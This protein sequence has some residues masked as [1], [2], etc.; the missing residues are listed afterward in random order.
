M[1]LRP[2]Q[3][4]AYIFKPRVCAEGGGRGTVLPRSMDMTERLRLGESAFKERLGGAGPSAEGIE[5]NPKCPLGRVEALASLSPSF[6]AKDKGAGN[7][8]SRPPCCA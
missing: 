7:R 8:S 3:V 4:P 1:R 2:L 5:R 6:E